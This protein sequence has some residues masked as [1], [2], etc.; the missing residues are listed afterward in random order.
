MH[1]ARPLLACGHMIKPRTRL[2]WL[3]LPVSALILLLALS[4][5]KTVPLGPSL[6]LRKV[7]LCSL[8]VS[9]VWPRAVRP[10]TR[11]LEVPPPLVSKIVLADGTFILIP[12]SLGPPPTVTPSP[13]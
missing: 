7:T 12:D 13:S 2:P 6:T 4:R 11:S 9:L 8:Q 1:P 10:V 3:T 5:W